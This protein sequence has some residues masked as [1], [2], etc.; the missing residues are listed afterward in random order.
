M[1]HLK[2]HK[3]NT[4]FFFL[5]LPVFLYC[6]FCVGKMYGR[7][8]TLENV[9][10]EYL[11]A[12]KDFWKFSIT[13]WTGRGLLGSVLVWLVMMMRSFGNNRHL[14]PGLEHGSARFGHPAAT[15]RKLTGRKNPGYVKIFSEN[16][17]V[18]M[19]TSVTKRNNN[20]VVIGGSGAGKTFFY[21][22]INALQAL[23]S[24]VFTDPKAELAKK[25][26]N[27]L[28]M[29][30]YRVLIFNLIEMEKSCHYN[31]FDYIHSDSDVVKMVTSILTNTMPKGSAPSDPFWEH[32]LGLMLQ[33][34]IHYVKAEYPKMGK[35]ANFRGLMDL[36]LLAKVSEK[37]GEQSE[38]DKLMFALPESHPARVAYEK[39]KSGAKDTMRSIII[40]AH[41]R[42]AYLQNEELL[43]ILDDDD[44]DIRSIGEGVYKNPERKTALFCV[45][46]DNDKSYNFLIGILYTQ[47][48]QEL[49]RLADFDYNGSLPVPVA[50]WLDEFAN[51][52]LPE[53]F[54]EILSTM[55]S[56][57]ISCNIIL[58]NKA[59]LQALFKDSWQTIIGN[60]DTRLYLGCNEPD[61]HKYIS[62]MLGRYTV[63]KKSTGETLGNHGSSSRNYD[64]L[65]RELMTPDEVGRLDNS[66]C[67]IFISGY[68]PVLDDKCHTW[69]KPVY[70]ISQALGLYE[71]EKQLDDLD[72]AGTRDFFLF[73]KGEEGCRKAFLYMM[74]HYQAVIKETP[75]FQEF[76]PVEGTFFVSPDRWGTYQV[77]REQGQAEVRPVVDTRQAQIVEDISET[78]TRFPVIG[79]LEGKQIQRLTEE[80]VRKLFRNSNLMTPVKKS[81]AFSNEKLHGEKH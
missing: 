36:L 64:V 11:Y 74:E 34:L 32:A 81:L 55:R 49:Y 4:M 48:F 70:Q 3:R 9:W 47:M 2:N 41:A 77:I 14:I 51:V 76:V 66:K 80:S 27:H 42:L 33:S 59:Q 67:I 30:G 39:F 1:E 12:L 31:P 15:T 22:L 56:R 50:F 60:C 8:I 44:I 6:G 5:I 35:K 52:A 20:T 72:E 43:R 69:E 7:T 13:P 65:G 71:G 57:N 29:N 75:A 61:T 62:E 19:D 25:L 26:T 18:S 53:G 40:S 37:D 10:E 68:P 78:M 28:K 46:P 45:I 38:L 79:Y 24:M 73:A 23:T 16:V 54:T 17:R 58:Q 21:V 63:E